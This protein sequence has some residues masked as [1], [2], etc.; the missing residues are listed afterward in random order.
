MTLLSPRQWSNQGP[1][2]NNGENLREW[3]VR[4]A[5]TILS[6]ENGTKTVEYDLASNLPILF[7]KPG[8]KEFSSWIMSQHLTTNEARIRPTALTMRDAIL[9]RETATQRLMQRNQL[10]KKDPFGL[11]RAMGTETS[12]ADSTATPELEDFHFDEVTT[13]TQAPMEP[14]NTLNETDKR[15][16]MLRWHYRLGHMSFKHLKAMAR[17]GMLNKRL[18]TIKEMPFCPGCHFGKQSRRAWRHRS[19]KKDGSRKRLRKARRPGEVV[20]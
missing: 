2:R 20:S 8:Y 12:H 13:D 11:K 9:P 5:D 16:L 15:T 14:L 18:A 6:F 1:T 17:Q 7:S 19:K 3:L 10:Q 4:G